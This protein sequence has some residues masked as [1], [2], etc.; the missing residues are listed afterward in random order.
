MENMTLK[1][2]ISGE[3]LAEIA[4]GEIVEVRIDKGDGGFYT[5]EGKVSQI[6]SKAEFTPTVIQ[7]KE[8][9]V[10]LVYAMDINVKNDGKIKIGMPAEV[11]F[12]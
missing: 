8:E 11:L 1:A 2:W 3:Q 10:D 4:I 5:Y 7:T 9:R 12:Q 6:A